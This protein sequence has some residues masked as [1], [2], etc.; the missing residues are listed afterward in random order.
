VDFERMLKLLAKRA[1]QQVGPKV[2]KAHSVRGVLM[3]HLLSLRTN[4]VKDEALSTLGTVLREAGAEEFM[5]LLNP[6]ASA[7]ANLPPVSIL[8]AGLLSP[9]V[10]TISLIIHLSQVFLVLIPTLAL[11]IWAIYIDRNTLAG[12]AVPTIQVWVFAQAAIALIL[13]VAHLM[14]TAAIQSSK[15]SINTKVEG[16]KDRLREAVSDGELSI[17]EIRELLI[18]VSILL[19]HS[20]VE[21]DK[22]RRSV[23]RSVIGYGTMVWMATVL[24]TFVIVLGWTFVPGMVAFHAAAAGVAGDDFCGAWATVFTARL[25]CVLSLLFLLFNTL[26]VVQFISDRLVT[27][28]SY[29]AAVLSHARA[30]DQTMLGLPV[31]E[32]FVKAFLLRGTGESFKA[33]IAVSRGQSQALEK[34]RDALSAKAEELSRR[35][36]SYEEEAAAL[37]K[38]AGLKDEDAETQ[39]QLQAYVDSEV[40][41]AK[42]IEKETKE[43]IDRLYEKMVAAAANIRNQS[44]DAMT[45]AQKQAAEGLESAQQAAGQAAASG[46]DLAAQARQQAEQQLGR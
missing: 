23:W 22:L 43:E 32:T 15:S 13:M 46:A 21:E 9:V 18:I 10:L 5:L 25:T 20:L 8:L 2:A 39:A 16:M 26:S 12:C 28:E 30:F 17:D 42:Q 41:R 11:C 24:W 29:S 35:I 6:S 33:Q 27:S 36:K 1:A 3:G 40:A 14:M 38:E 19:E 45:A 7:A 37:K 44:L 34:Q 31:V 4:F